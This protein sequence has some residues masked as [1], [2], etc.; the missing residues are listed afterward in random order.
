MLTVENQKFLIM[1]ARKNYSRSLNA[2]NN[3]DYYK[4][5]YRK[6]ANKDI[7][8]LLQK[9]IEYFYSILN[10]DTDEAAIDTYWHYDTSARDGFMDIIQEEFCFMDSDT[11]MALS[12]I[13][14]TAMENNNRAAKTIYG[15]DAIRAILKE[16]EKLQSINSMLCRYAE[17][18][19]DKE[20]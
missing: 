4:R 15:K 6:D 14:I 3:S 5:T 17:R 13:V 8:E 9:D 1:T 20:D 11:L 18:L 12:E 2:V 16:N 7:A 19:S 10:A